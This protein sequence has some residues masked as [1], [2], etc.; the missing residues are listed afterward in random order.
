MNQNK[1]SEDLIKT[2]MEQ[3]VGL[4]AERL[5]DKKLKAL[6]KFERVHG[7]SD[8]TLLERGKI[9]LEKNSPEIAIKY[10]KQSLQNKKNLETIHKLSICYGKLDL[11]NEA[12]E[13]FEEHLPDFK[14]SGAFWCLLAYYKKKVG[15]NHAAH[16]AAY[17]AIAKFDQVAPAVWRILHNAGL[18][19]ERYQEGYE[20]SKKYIIK[21]NNIDEILVETFIGN[22]LQLGVE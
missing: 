4:K 5:I 8:G 1:F 10:L 19:I 6:N 16:S 20:L 17:T 21:N 18:D 22:C 11:D 3:P 13:L 15:D 7:K 14:W 9:Y 2:K 12:S